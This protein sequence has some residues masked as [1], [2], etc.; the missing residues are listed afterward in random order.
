MGAD[1]PLRRARVSTVSRE[2]TDMERTFYAKLIGQLV[3]ARKRKRLSQE[4]LD[5]QLGVSAGLVAKWEC[6]L[7]MP[8][9]FMLVCWAQAVEVDLVVTHQI[10]KG[11]TDA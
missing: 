1:D 6:Y 8:S 5:H 9:T 11:Q 7:R 10:L 2:A 4:Q 3:V